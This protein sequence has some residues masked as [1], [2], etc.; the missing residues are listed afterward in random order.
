MVRLLL[1]DFGRVKDI[2]TGGLHSTSTDA[3]SLRI[4]DHVIDGDVLT[5]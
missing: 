4:D 2:G 5:T 3:E 1:R